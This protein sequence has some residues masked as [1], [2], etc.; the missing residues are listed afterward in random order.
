MCVCVCILAERTA[1]IFTEAP[2]Q[3]REKEREGGREVYC[4]CKCY[5]DHLRQ[6]VK[7]PYGLLKEVPC[8][9]DKLPP[10]QSATAA[11]DTRLPQVC[12]LVQA[13]P[14][15]CYCNSG[16]IRRSGV[17]ASSPSSPTEP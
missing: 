4:E 6:G 8:A 17:S 14:S 13:S 9:H 7:V 3:E 10:P 5:E 12:R 16:I 15:R 1:V 2:Q 11:T